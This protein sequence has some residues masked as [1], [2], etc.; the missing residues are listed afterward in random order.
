MF[1]GLYVPADDEPFA[2][3]LIDQG[4]MT[5]TAGLSMPFWGVSTGGHTV[6]YILTN[7]FN[8]EITF[9]RDGVR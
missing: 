3:F 1:E 5:T 8:N 4:E 2:K 9:D 6:T 7:Q